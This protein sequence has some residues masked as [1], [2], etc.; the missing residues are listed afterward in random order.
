MGGGLFVAFQSFALIAFVQSLSAVERVS[1]FAFP[2]SRPHG[3][4]ASSPHSL[5]VAALPDPWAATGSIAV[6][7]VDDATNRP[8]KGATVTGVVMADATYIKNTVT[9]R[10]G[11]AL[12][13]GL[14][15]GRVRISSG[16]EGYLSMTYGA[17][18]PG[19]DGTYITVAEGQQAPAITIRLKRG[20]VVAGTI[21]NEAGEPLVGVPVQAFRKTF[22]G[23]RVRFSASQE[24]DFTDDRGSYRIRNLIP[25]EYLIGV[26]P[27]TLRE[28]EMGSGVDSAV[29]FLDPANSERLL[30]TDLGDDRIIAIVT[31]PLPLSVGP[32]FYPGAP[33]ARAIGI[34]IGPAELKDGVDFQ[35]TPS[36]VVH[37]SGRLAG[38]DEGQ[39]TASVSLVP[40]DDEARTVDTAR[41]TIVYEPSTPFGFGSVSPGR[42]VLEVR[43]N[44]K[45]VG[46]TPM[47]GRVPLVVGTAPITDL[48]VTMR[49]GMT[50]TGQV[51]F[52]TSRV[53]SVTRSLAGVQVTLTDQAQV[54]LGAGNAHA[55]LQPDGHFEF[56]DLPPGN[57]TLRVDGLPYGWLAASAVLDG[58][59]ALDFGLRI[60]PGS[61]IEDFV[62]TVA[63]KLPE[64]SGVLRDA[65]DRPTTAGW[66]ILFPVDKTYWPTAA[67]RTLGVRPGV[68]GRFVFRLVA[69]G[70]YFVAAADAEQ[71]QW[72]D[73]SFLETLVP[74]AMRVDVKADSVAAVKPIVLRR[75]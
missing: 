47:W 31:D 64:V 18:R 16:H 49:R 59:D 34:K 53:E 17:E 20:A 24:M 39:I 66:V 2:S 57:Y 13:L 3:L 4:I 5:Q 26:V 48:I 19:E 28:T 73:P 35:L 56:H 29:R 46:L 40:V 6:R 38:L 68:D 14:A 69:P 61:N 36:P 21:T 58:R 67:R 8:I 10:D 51:R 33:A 71:G 25:G 30:L 43:A 54:P 15:T 72:Q 55:M 11:R 37:V 63:D 41:H 50:V 1:L 9:D 75:Q 42:Y 60:D 7:V 22:S 52:M 44:E 23:D 45:V 12:L 62:V 32:T 70:D 74:R 27:R 65:S